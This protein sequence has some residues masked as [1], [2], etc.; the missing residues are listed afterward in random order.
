MKVAVVP[1]FCMMMLDMCPSGNDP[2]GQWMVMRQPSNHHCAAMSV[3]SMG[4]AA[5]MTEKMGTYATQ[6]Q[7]VAA[8][9]AFQ[10]QTDSQIP[11]MMVCEQ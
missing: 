4:S 5:G 2:N 8:L 6:S 11:T 7:A 1:V 3:T 9:Q 10:S